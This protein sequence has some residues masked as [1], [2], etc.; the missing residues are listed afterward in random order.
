MRT[1]TKLSGRNYKISSSISVI[2][3]M[4]LFFMVMIKIAT[5]SIQ[6]INENKLERIYEA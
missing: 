6:A 3:L 5:A 2:T 1:K 4:T